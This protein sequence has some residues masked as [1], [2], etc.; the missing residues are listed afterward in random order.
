MDPITCNKGRS[1]A[2]H[3]LPPAKRR[4]RLIARFMRARVE[5]QTRS[6]N[7]RYCG[8]R[9]QYTTF[10]ARRRSESRTCGLGNALPT[11]YVH[12]SCPYQGHNRREYLIIRHDPVLYYSSTPKASQQSKAC[13]A[14]ANAPVTVNAPITINASLATNRRF[15]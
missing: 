6:L 12:E 11:V 9:E 7:L 8:N 10:P 4:S 15:C 3:G 2:P 14:P 5:P 13:H 1:R